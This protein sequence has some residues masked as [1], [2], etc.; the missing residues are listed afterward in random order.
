MKI[1]YAPL[2][3][4]DIESILNYIAQDNPAAAE[5][6]RRAIVAAVKTVAGNPY[7]GT[8]NVRNPQLRSH[9]LGRYPYRVHYTVRGN[10]IVVLHVRHGSRKP[11]ASQP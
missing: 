11:W 4:R 8:K 3:I 9:L 7:L 5:K 6:V 2:A 1:R 10:E